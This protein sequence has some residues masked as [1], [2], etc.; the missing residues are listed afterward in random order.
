MP[1]KWKLIGSVSHKVFI[2]FSLK[3]ECLN[4]DSYIQDYSLNNTADD[5]VESWDDTVFPTNSQKQFFM[6]ML[7]NHL[8]IQKQVYP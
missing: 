5:Y 1:E 4:E 7:Y 6:K 8:L 2:P 3:D